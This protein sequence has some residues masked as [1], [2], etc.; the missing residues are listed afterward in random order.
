MFIIFT[1]LSEMLQSCLVKFLFYKALFGVFLLM[2]MFSFKSSSSCNFKLLLQLK[3]LVCKI[4]W[5]WFVSIHP[6]MSRIHAQQNN[7]GLGR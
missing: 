4:K 5:K 2:S 3:I 7:R 6:L 1:S